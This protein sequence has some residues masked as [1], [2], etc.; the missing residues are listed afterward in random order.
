M[1]GNT[2]GRVDQNRSDRHEKQDANHPGGCGP[3]NRHPRLGLLCLTFYNRMAAVVSRV[4][5]AGALLPID[6]LTHSSHSPALSGIPPIM[7][8]TAL[9]IAIAAL[10]FTSPALADSDGVYVAVGY[11]GRRMSSRDG[12]TWENVQQ[13]ADKGADDSNNLISIAYGHGKFVCVGGG[14]W[15]KETQAG[16]ILLSEDGK[17]WREVAKYPFRVSPILFTGDRFVAGGPSRQFLYSDDGVTWKEGP[18]VELPKE[19]PSWAFWFRKG[20]A[21]NGTYIFMGNAGKDQKIWWC[22]T[23]HDGTAITHFATDLPQVKGLTF[24][25]GKFVIA[26]ADGILTSADGDK[27]SKVESAPN[28]ELRG[29]IFNGK[30]FLLTGK[31]QLYS[32]PDAKTWTPMGKSPPGNLL[33]ADEKVMIAT[34][35]PGKMFACTDGKTWKPTGQPMP[36]MG[37]NEIAHGSGGK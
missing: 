21:G 12:V 4:K 16:H 23:T 14:G 15:S 13:W 36:A 17:D 37:V 5:S 19:I 34:G 7:I 33:H 20:A 32:S 30:S 6:S 31:Q 24:G 22:L 2:P 18:K 25:N 1:A 9:L 29:V 28:D 10:N 35:W 11:G 27:W 26:T 8:R 3:R